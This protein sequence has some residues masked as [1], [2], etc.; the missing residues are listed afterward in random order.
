M[1]VGETLEP[2][3][4]SH[5]DHPWM[6]RMDRPDRLIG[7]P[8]RP[9]SRP[10]RRAL[11]VPSQTRMSSDTVRT[12][13][14]QLAKTLLHRRSVNSYAVSGCKAIFGPKRRCIFGNP[15][16]KLQPPTIEPVCVPSAKFRTFQIRDRIRYRRRWR[17]KAL[18]V[19]Q[20]DRIAPLRIVPDHENSSSPGCR[21]E[22]V[23]VQSYRTQYVVSRRNQIDGRLKH[24]ARVALCHAQDVF[25]HERSW[26][27]FRHKAKEVPQQEPTRVFRV[28]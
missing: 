10:Q 15:V 4:L 1:P 2:R 21:T 8:V 19:I 9:R 28:P 23:G 20:T 13:L 5:R 17:A 12:S 24:M 14:R 27:N 26:T 7:A 22:I 6:F 18:Y 11:P 16:P 3:R 25:H